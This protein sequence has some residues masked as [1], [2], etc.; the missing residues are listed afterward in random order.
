ML[1]CKAVM[2]YIYPRKDMN[3]LT[4]TT[5]GQITLK[6]DLLKHLGLQPG[7]RVAVEK[8]PDGRIEIHAMKPSGKISDV[9]GMLKREGR[10]PMSIEEM[11]EIIGKGWA[12]EL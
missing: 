2:P 8:L 1:E 5:K 11:N 3:A 9:F 12:G 7:D 6:K 4:I 10:K